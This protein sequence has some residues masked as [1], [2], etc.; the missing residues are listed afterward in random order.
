MA[1]RM[2]M[3]VQREFWEHKALYVAP[4]VMGGLIVFG[5]T[6]SFIWSVIQ[7]A[8]FEAAV[9][10]VELGGEPI[11]LA[12]SAALFGVSSGML[13]FVLAAVVF[14]YSID[15]LYSE[16]KDKSI[17]FWRSMPV[18]DTETVLS[19]LVT[20]VIAAPIVTVA[21][22][23]VTLFC[24][25]ILFTLALMVGGGN[26][27]ELLWQ[28]TPFLQMV[29]LVFYSFITA[30]LW[31]AP[32]VGYFLFCSSFA[33]RWALLWVLLPITVVVM[34][35]AIVGRSFHVL[36]LIGE[37]FESVGPAAFSLPANIDFDG[38][39][40]ES[41]ILGADLNLLEVMS[42]IQFLTTPGLWGGFA[43]TAVFVAGA[44]YFRRSRA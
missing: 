10:S 26:P 32:F 6:V 18:T 33:K 29:L 28:Q 37:R 30:S 43:V 36:S 20:A 5:F 19:K 9:A 42:P 40:I 21:A 25:W 4:A 31:F 1:A 16:R 38:D 22:V 8:P 14:F 34:L 15:A 27:I 12:G 11:G 41:F 13:N 39:D 17:L 24:L 2:W 23:L 44:I 7:G 35:E 3:L